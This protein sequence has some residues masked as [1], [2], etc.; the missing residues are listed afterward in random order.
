MVTPEVVG[1]IDPVCLVERLKTNGKPGNRR[2]GLVGGADR[3]P[4]HPAVCNV[5]ADLEAEGSREKARDASGS[6]CG[7]KVE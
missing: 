4:A 2:A 6:S 3:G 1:Y 7:R 5:V